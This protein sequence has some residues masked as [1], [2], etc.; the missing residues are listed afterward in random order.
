M[1][2]LLSVGGRRCTGDPKNVRTRRKRA[3]ARAERTKVAKSVRPARKSDR[4]LRKNARSAQVGRT[5]ARD[6]DFVVSNQVTKT[7]DRSGRRAPLC[8]KRDTPE[9]RTTRIFR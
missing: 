4:N 8:Q 9:R 3:F 6:I 1:S 7:C 2:L 5:A